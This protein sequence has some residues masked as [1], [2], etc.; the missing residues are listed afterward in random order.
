[1]PP[2]KRRCREGSE[3]DPPEGEMPQTKPGPE[4]GPT[5]SLLVGWLETTSGTMANCNA[6]RSEASGTNL[7]ST[8]QAHL[9]H[10]HAHQVPC[11]R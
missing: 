6:R 9:A 10:A 7:R 4:E 3:Q 1:M 2:R 11:L 8:V 5:Y